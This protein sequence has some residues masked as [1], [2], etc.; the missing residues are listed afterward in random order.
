[1]SAPAV[2]YVDA[3]APTLAPT[4]S[5]N[6]VL[7]HGAATTSPKAVDNNSGVASASCD[8]HRHEQ[9]GLEDRH[10]HGD[11]HGGQHGDCDRRVQRHLRLQRL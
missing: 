7:L 5:P 9:R 3:T 8:H 1:M 11:G 6:P 10:L 2:F 4:V